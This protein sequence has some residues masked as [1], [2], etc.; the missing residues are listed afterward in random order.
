MGCVIP[1]SVLQH[2]SS[3]TDKPRRNNLIDKGV[4]IVVVGIV[5]VPDAVSG[6][7]VAFVV[8]GEE[9]NERITVLS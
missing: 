8:F 5:T 1:Q 7:V 4:S 6:V 3:N 2:T 9:H